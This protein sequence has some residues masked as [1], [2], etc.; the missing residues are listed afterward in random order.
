[1]NQDTDL[2]TFLNLTP[3]F[4]GLN[5]SL[6][7]ELARSCHLRKLGK[8]QVLFLQLDDADHVYVVRKGIVLIS[9]THEDGR[10]LV[11]NEMGIGDIFGEL[12]L[13]SGKTRSADAI[14]RIRSEVVVIPTEILQRMLDH[15][16][17][18]ARR[19]LVILSERLRLS[20]NRETS[21]AFLDAQA[22][23]AHL[24]LELDQESGSKGY[25]NLTQTELGQRLGLARQTVAKILGKWRCAGWLITGRGRVMILRPEVLS[26]IA[27]RMAE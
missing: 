19:M 1:M 3:L 14:A 20:T 2:K 21:L 24:L 5:D 12:S 27:Q 10:E 25:I 8:G 9:V 17:E 18:L 7:D 16:P 13:F 26:E 11:L 6:I 15:S 22:R 4:A 23:V